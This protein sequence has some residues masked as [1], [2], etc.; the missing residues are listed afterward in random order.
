[1]KREIL[2]ALT[3]LLAG[4]AFAGVVDK[5]AALGGF[6]GFVERMGAGTRELGRGNTGTADTSAMPGAY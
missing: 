6:D 3:L 2:L 5:K 4:N 1:M